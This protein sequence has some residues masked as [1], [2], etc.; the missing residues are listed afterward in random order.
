MSVKQA[1]SAP[2]CRARILCYTGDHAQICSLHLHCLRP[3][4]FRF[5]DCHIHRHDNGQYE[6]LHEF[7]LSGSGPRVHGAFCCACLHHGLYGQSPQMGLGPVA[8]ASDHGNCRSGVPLKV[9]IALLVT[10]RPADHSAAIYPPR[11]HA[12]CQPE[13]AVL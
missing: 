4:V 2:V 8:G 1:E 5:V 9:R 3:F 12:R 13:R 6:P 7:W 11:G 10:R